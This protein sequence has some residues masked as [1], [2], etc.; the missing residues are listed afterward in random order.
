MQAQFPGPVATEDM[1]EFIEGTGDPSL[2]QCHTRIGVLKVSYSCTQ[3]RPRNDNP[4]RNAALSPNQE[5]VDDE[6]RLSKSVLSPCMSP[7]LA[8]RP[9]PGRGADGSTHCK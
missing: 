3:T 9:R 1:Q 2:H 6:G 8:T 5:P 4:Q 7:A